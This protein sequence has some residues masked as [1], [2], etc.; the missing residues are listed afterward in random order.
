M[1]PEALANSRRW[2]IFS[3]APSLHRKSN[4]LDWDFGKVIDRIM[5]AN[6]CLGNIYRNSHAVG[7]LLVVLDLFC[8]SDS[9]NLILCFS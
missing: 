9:S 6:I 7:L 2:I 1:I 5:E 4:A 8:E 3:I